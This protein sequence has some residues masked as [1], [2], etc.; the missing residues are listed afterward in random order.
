MTKNLNIKTLAKGMRVEDKA[1]LLFADRNKRAETKGKE[2]LL[3]P[4]E[5][6]AL[7]EDAQNLHQINELN[8]LN[9]LYNT[10]SFLILDIQTAYLNFKLAEGKLL[11]IL[12]GMILVGEAN[13]T[14]E[15]VM[16]ELTTQGYSKEQLEDKQFQDEVE[17][18][19]QEYLKKYRS[20]GLT[21]IYDYF[22]PGLRNSNYFSTKSE[23]LSEPN[24]ILQK[25]FMSVIAEVR[26]FK[27]Q[28]YYCD[29][30][31]AKAKIP[32]LSER[33]RYTVESFTQDVNS[34]VNLDGHLSL[35]QMYADF[36]DKGML[37]S[38]GLTEPKFIET[39]KNMNK[40]TRLGRKAR[41]RAEI[42]LEEVINKASFLT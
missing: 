42:E 31:E 23:M 9:R 15:N 12:T 38:E 22:E 29:Y 28:V 2:G 36:A 26:R 24:L 20:N 8:K 5:E 40:A 18:K 35:I 41:T 25:I 16:C 19:A 13:D 32:L 37:K 4:D 1:K 30:V 39:I 14:L 27:K 6:K 10:A 7:V 11:T 17:N 21:K 3:T 34:F 33:D